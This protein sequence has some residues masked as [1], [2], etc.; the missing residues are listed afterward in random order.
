MYL[1]VIGAFI[2]CE[3]AELKGNFL[4]VRLLL[5]CTCVNKPS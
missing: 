1:C 5:H 4:D 2:I 3:A